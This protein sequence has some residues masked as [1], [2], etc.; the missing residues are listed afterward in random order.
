M[1]CQRVIGN[2]GSAE[3][4]D[5]GSDPTPPLLKQQLCEYFSSN[6]ESR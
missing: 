2:E 6:H 3:N 4:E 5:D 1:E